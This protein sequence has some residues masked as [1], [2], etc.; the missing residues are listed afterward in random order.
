MNTYAF[1]IKEALNFGFKKFKQNTGV[2]VAILVVLFLVSAVLNGLQKLTDDYASVASTLFKIVALVVQL[3]SAM[4]I[5]RISL[6]I[7]KDSR[8]KF[9]DIL[10]ETHRF[11][12]YMVAYFLFF[13]MTFLGLILLI[14]P[15]IIWASTY[16]FY[17]YIL[18]DEKEKPIASLKKSKELTKNNRLQIFYFLL[19]LL[20]INLLGALLLGVGLLVTIPISFISMGY[21]YNKL[22]EKNN[23]KV[24]LE[25]VKVIETEIVK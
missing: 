25:T 17:G 11:L 23:S 18:I 22:K 19:V 24:I 8:I 7:Y 4:G 5:I 15:G 14:F 10:S 20:G 12:D 21:V 2:L 13:F 3:V 6:S 9:M 16:L 1:S